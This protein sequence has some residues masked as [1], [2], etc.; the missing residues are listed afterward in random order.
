MNADNERQKLDV[1]TSKIIGCV[2]EVSNTLGCGF[3]E[4]VYENALVLEL[5]K[6]GLT[7]KQQH[8]VAVQYKTSV[9]GDYFADILVNDCIILELKACSAL[10]PEHHSQCM[11]YLKA[12]HLKICLLINFGRSKVDIKR[13]VHQF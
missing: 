8:P 3:L 13:I 9:V 11:N 6:A 10:T 5:R 12:T 7:A 2:F 1:L 4:K